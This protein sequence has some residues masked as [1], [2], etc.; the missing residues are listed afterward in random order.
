M[1]KI[2]ACGILALMA[3]SSS[4]FAQSVIVG[5]GSTEEVGAGAQVVVD[6]DGV[7]VQFGG[8]FVMAGSSSS[9][10]Q[11]IC[12]T[13]GAS[14]AVQTGG[15]AQLSW[16]KLEN[17]TTLAVA[18]GG[19]LLR[20][21][22]TVFQDSLATGLPWIDISAVTDREG[23][24]FSFNRITFVGTVSRKN[25]KASAST[26]VVRV[27]GT[28]AGSTR[29]GVGNEDDPG[30]TIFW[31][32]GAVTRSSPAGTYDTVEE[33][34]RATGTVAGSVVT[35]NLGHTMI[36]D[37]VDFNTL[38]SNGASA[39]GPIV[40]NACLAPLVGAGIL[41]SDPDSTRRGKIVNC[42]LARGAVSETSAENCTFFDPS[43]S[44]VIAVNN[45]DCKNTLIESGYSGSGNNTPSPHCLTNVVATFFSSASTYDFHLGSGG[46]AAI[47]TGIALSVTT[48][49]EGTV[50]GLVGKSGGSPAWDIGADEV[51]CPPP[52][53]LAT[54]GESGNVL[55]E[56]SHNSETGITYNVYRSTQSGGPFT[57]LNASPLT[58][59]TFS[60]LAVAP[61]TYFYVVRGLDSSGE[62][63]NSVEVKVIL[64]QPPTGLAAAPGDGRVSL[65][66]SSVSGAIAYYVLRS[67]SA[68]SPYFFVGSSTSPTYLDQFIFN[69]RTYSYVVQSVSTTGDASANSSS[70]NATPVPAGVTSVLLIVDNASALNAADQALRTRIENLNYT[71]VTM[72][73]SAA[74]PSHGA[75]RA[76]VAISGT[77][78]PSSLAVEFRNLPVPILTWNNG[79]LGILGMTGTASGTDFGTV[80]GSSQL[81]VSNHSCEIISPI[82]GLPQPVTVLESGMTDTFGWGAPGGSAFAGATLPSDL[83]KAVLFCYPVGVAMPGLT[84]A[85]A[86]RVALFMSATGATSLNATGQMLFDESVQWS[87]GAPGR[88]NAVWTTVGSGQITVR[89]DASFGVTNYTVQRATSPGGTFTTV[90]SGLTDT[91]FVDTQ[92]TGGPFVYRIIGLNGFGQS[93]PSTP[94]APVAAQAMDIQIAIKGFPH[95]RRR[96]APDPTPDPVTHWN[97]KTYIAIIRA[98]GGLVPP[99]DVL[100]LEGETSCWTVTGKAVDETSYPTADPTSCFVVSKE[101][102]GEGEATLTF[103]C[104]IDTGP[105]GTTIWE[106]PPPVVATIQIKQK[107]TVQLKFHFP[108][109]STG[110]RTNRAGYPNLFANENNMEDVTRST[111]R[112]KLAA[113][114]AFGFGAGNLGDFGIARIWD[115][116]TIDFYPSP[117]VSN[118]PTE[119]ISNGEGVWTEDQLQHG[120]EAFAAIKQ[121]IGGNDV[122]VLNVFL[123]KSIKRKPTRVVDPLAFAYDNYSQPG[124]LPYIVLSDSVTP[125]NQESLAHELGHVFG[126]ERHA[127]ELIND[128]TAQGTINRMDLIYPNRAT[129][130][131]R[132]LMYST[133]AIID[134]LIGQWEAESSYW[135]L[136]NNSG[137]VVAARDD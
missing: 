116:A 118:D 124:R 14:I 7:V 19:K 16:A 43:V 89:W 134:R 64:L 29:W 44:L 119:T 31:H 122:N 8:S 22:E 82:T 114:L 12:L 59:P 92:V 110:K 45:I 117:Y 79:L 103:K 41:D 20:V 62:G 120:E 4:A 99:G 15:S 96:K 88:I 85:P 39:T 111:E 50:R 53:G 123:V 129:W 125:A 137:R 77:V 38:P 72:S 127:D 56:W 94:S 6:P 133:S 5:N 109:D 93:A 61:G 132:F 100:P 112:S 128:W 3:I 69:G 130:S 75:G 2:C 68:G 46:N 115:Q 113:E 106:Y 70:V 91:M 25:I 26:P 76:L 66:W 24:A 126:L 67:D 83:S 131:P 23:L 13:G 90:G 10:A 1:K 54:L 121:K 47:D 105:V 136:W 81:R 35:V 51:P 63:G 107:M 27:L 97:S 71:V 30:N 33:A 98:N 18:A 57:K 21:R 95:L 36:D 9:Q 80:S 32:S 34:L 78:T 87:T 17:L 135:N 37:V 65:S 40:V 11:W 86:R 84:A 73:A 101:G 104:R 74:Q 42:V 52:T 102:A 55:L 108:N 49:F 48:D 60:D 28:P 58:V